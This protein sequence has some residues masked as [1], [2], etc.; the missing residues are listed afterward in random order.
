MPPVDP[1][2][3]YTARLAARK[4]SSRRLDRQLDRLGLARLFTFAAALYR[5]KLDGQLD[6]TFGQQGRVA[7]DLGPAGVKTFGK[8]VA[9]RPSDNSIFVVGYN[10]V[11]ATDNTTQL[12]VVHLNADGAPDTGF[13]QNGVV[14]PDFG[15][16]AIS[17]LPCVL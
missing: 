17:G 1:C 3:A 5:Y 10:E 14:H 9:V 2:R 16:P 7:L 12:A 4:E 8:A 11:S 6:R 15:L 13:G